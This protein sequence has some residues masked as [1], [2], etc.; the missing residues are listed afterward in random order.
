MNDLKL[1][2]TEKRLVVARG[3]GRGWV[4]VLKRFKLLVIRQISPEHVQY[5]MVKKNQKD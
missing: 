3:R 5:G 4:K 2:D 1:I